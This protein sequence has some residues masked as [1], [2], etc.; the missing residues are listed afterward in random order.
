VLVACSL[1]AVLWFRNNDDGSVRGGWRVV[2]LRALGS[3]ISAIVILS[4]GFVMRHP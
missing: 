3:W 1:A 4:G 2:T